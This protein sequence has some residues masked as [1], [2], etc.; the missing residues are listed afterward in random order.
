M[1]TEP[2]DVLR[3]SARL[4][5]QGQGDFVNVWHF[6]YDVGTPL[7]DDLTIDLVAERLDA[8]YDLIK[9]F[10]ANDAAFVDINVFNVTQ[11]RPLGSTPWP[12]LVNGLDS[13]EML[14]GQVA[15]FVRFPSGFSRNWA[16]KFIGPMTVGQ[17]TTTGLMENAT[18]A[19]LVAF[20]SEILTGTLAG[21]TTDLETIVYYARTQQWVAVTSAIVRN[22]WATVRTRR[23]GRGG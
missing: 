5:I 2:Q 11:N 9:S 4:S 17:N 10:I 6:R 8:A 15:A 7:S 3:A 21:S 12:T 22:V 23:S 20:A 1:P 19:A 13:D 14:P 18:V 16:K